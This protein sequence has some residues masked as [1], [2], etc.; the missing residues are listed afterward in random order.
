MSSFMPGQ[1]P[2]DVTWVRYCE[3]LG[4]Q[5]QS[6]RVTFTEY[7]HGVTLG[8]IS[9][10]EEQ[11]QQCVDAIPVAVLPQYVDFLKSWLVPADFMPSPRPFLVRNDS[12]TDAEAAQARLKPKYVRLYRL[13]Q[14]RM[15][16]TL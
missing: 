9:A 5:V 10:P 16:L 2:E 8:A 7:A 4:R 1:Q 12:E 6:D 11:L 3:K 15:A 14:D 13:V